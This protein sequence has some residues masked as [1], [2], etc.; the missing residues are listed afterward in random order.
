[1]TATISADLA[2]LEKLKAAQQRVRDQIRTVVVGQ[3]DVVEQLL[4]SIFAKATASSKVSPVSR[5][6]CL[7]R[8]S[9]GHCHSTSDASSSHQT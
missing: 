8:H 4:V 3:D 6:H 7:C 9:P 5:R 2:A 1:M